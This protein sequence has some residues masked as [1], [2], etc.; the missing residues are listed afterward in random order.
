M[1]RGVMERV[2]LVTRPLQDIRCCD[3]DSVTLEAQVDAP[4]NS[5]IRWEKQGKL[6]KLGGDLESEWDGSRVRLRIREVYPE[7]EGEYSCIILGDQGKA[8]TSATLVVEMADDKENDVTVQ[9]DHRPDLSRRTTPSRTTPSRYSRSPSFQRE[10]SAHSWAGVGWREPS[11]TVSHWRPL[12][13]GSSPLLLARRRTPDP[14][15]R[16]KA[17][18]SHGPKFYYIP[19]DRIVEEGETVTFQC[20]VKGH[21]IPRAVWDKDS[22]KLH[23][24]G[25]YKMEAREET[26][27]LE[28]PKV[29]QQ[30]AGL[31]RVTI[32]NDLGREQATARLDVIKASGNKYAGHV[33]SWY[34]SPLTPPQFTRSMP[35]TRVRDGGRLY[36]STE[37][38]GSPVPRAKW[39]R[40]HELLPMCE[41]FVQCYD[42]RT[43]SLEIPSVTSA[44]AGTYT[45]VLVNDAGKTECSCEV[46]VEH[47]NGKHEQS[48][49]FLQEL[50]DLT[51]LDGD[52]VTLSVK[53]SGTQPMKV[54]W[55]R[56]EE[57]LP[58]SQ[59]FRYQ[60]DGS[61]M[62]S[63]VIR[64]IF[65]ED[66]GV[67]IC[68]AYNSH[69]DAHCYCRLTVHDPCALQNSPPQ[70]VGALTPLE[71]EEGSAAR[72]SVTVHGFPQPSVSWFCDGRKLDP[73]P[74]IKVEA[75]SDAGISEPVKH[76][77]GILH[78][79]STDSGIIS[80]VASNCLGSDTTTTTLKVHPYAPLKSSEKE[81]T[82][83]SPTTTTTTTTASITTSDS[84]APRIRPLLKEVGST[85]SPSTDSAYCSVSL[86]DSTSA[87]SSSLSNFSELEDDHT[88]SKDSSKTK[89]VKS[90]RFK[91]EPEDVQDNTNGEANEE[92]E[93]VEANEEE[94]EED[95]E[96]G[97]E[98]LEGPRDITVL[99]GQSATFTATFT[100]NPKPVVS[101]L[102]KEQP[103]T[104]GGRYQ[105]KTEEGRTSLTIHDVVQ[106][107]CDKYTIV[108]RNS[109]CAHAAFASLAV[110]SAPEP[111]ADKPNF[112]EVTA[113]SATLSWYGP[114]YDGGSVV[115]GY[116]VEAR[117]IGMDDWY[118]LISGCHSTSYI[119]RGL[120]KNCEYEFRVRAQN[121]HGMSEP[122]RPSCP[123][124]I[125]DQSE[126]QEPEPEDHETT[127]APLDVKIESGESFD[128]QYKLHEEVGK[129]R[130]GI[131]YR[132]TEKTTGTRRAAKI[133]K[134]IRAADKEKVKE[135]IDIMNALRH[136][137]LL[138]LGAAYERQREFIMVMEY[139]S[140]GE[141]FE[142]VV[143]DDFALTERDCILFV[144]QICDGVNYMHK[145][146]IVHLDLKPENILCVRKTSHQIKLI[147]FGLARRFNPDDPCRVLFGTPE[148][149]APEV[150]NYEP[151]GFAS[152]MWS[153]GVIC[154]VL[155]SG[156][157]PF[158]GDSDAET[159]ANITRAE[160][161][162]D[163]D[164]FDAI[165]DD[166]KDFITSLLIHKKENRLTAEQCFNHPWLAQTEADMNK[167]VIS[168]DKL[169]KFIIR[170]KWQKTG[171]AL[172][173]LGRITSLTN[174]RSSQPSSPTRLTPLP[175]NQTQTPPSPAASTTKSKGCAPVTRPSH[176]IVSERSD[177]GI[178]EC[179]FNVEENSQSPPANQFGVTNSR[180]VTGR[181]VLK[182][183]KTPS[184]DW[185]S[186]VDSAVCD[187]DYISKS[188]YNSS[189]RKISREG[190]LHA[191]TAADAHSRI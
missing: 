114:T 124:T 84:P 98:I 126:E 6:L 128:K 86:R 58:D 144:R 70:I 171:N 175:E 69:G 120:E 5:T 139:I 157:S 71:V 159:F 119:A 77:L 7:D 106:K 135:E 41:D 108:V 165:S 73:T 100:G 169:K 161:D 155:L 163:D 68:E 47:H 57:V 168:T 101:W 35:S 174:R 125:Q 4:K 167:V 95:E 129:G 160:F 10:G 183:G 140:G 152:D 113:D 79:L 143:A 65:P 83:A 147:D 110:G 52:E 2:P 13:R 102:K 36:L 61:G 48:P 39:Y 145:N 56:N 177:S 189:P 104:E 24:G 154:Y 92:D 26:R 46:V 25:R 132:V 115:T 133:I 105:V 146:L 30:D 32:E 50:Q 150:I 8:V 82:S 122:S 28:I 81:T 181:N 34:S 190:L 62:H 107:D 54:V 59:D 60:E 142:R 170:R 176:S 44:D 148:F 78:A 64:D 116:T 87:C 29:T 76:V 74:R 16:S 96:T 103:I 17:K 33:R 88:A 127:F 45:C 38:R 153:V 72:F 40:N 93:E 111:P 149:I 187:D 184:L 67:Y 22:L 66:A 75:D 89:T 173:A 23:E 37:Y 134:C 9:L 131:V 94:D 85:A 20:A 179:S 188:S 182:S 12:S 55:V 53:L 158:M 63:L 3:G 51:V 118:I 19:H 97:V 137:K 136:P 191:K 117:K 138:Q 91:D 14:I 166:A 90:I 178:S 121:V 31:Y 43:A 180:A 99:K 49:F 141:L 27:T 151:I 1:R 186:S 21:P 112:C 156:L 109:L 162:F 185:Q 42:G 15:P 80:V 164:A 11:I 18:R 123:V 130:F 172:R